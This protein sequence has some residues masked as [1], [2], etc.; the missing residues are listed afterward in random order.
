MSYPIQQTLWESIDGILFNKALVLA[1]E[2]AAE[3]GVPPQQLIEMMKKE[4]R[5]KFTIIPDDEESLYQCR[6]IVH[7]GFVQM[8][9]RN[10]ILGSP[11]RLCNCHIV[12]KYTADV[13]GLPEL[14]RI[15]TPDAIYFTDG[16]QVYDVNAR[17]CGVLKDQQ[18]LT[19]FQIEDN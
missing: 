18:K 14:Q 6:A 17:A 16:E 11:T 3:L 15:V 19:V 5:G 10:P 8:R 4:E 12:E 9:C 13:K 2:V 1:K 7:N